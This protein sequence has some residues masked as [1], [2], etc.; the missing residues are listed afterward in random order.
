MRCLPR[1]KSEIDYLVFVFFKYSDIAFEGFTRSFE[2]FHFLSL[3]TLYL[4]PCG[5]FTIII[6]LYPYTKIVSYLDTAFNH[7]LIVITRSDHKIISFSSLCLIFFIFFQLIIFFASIKEIIYV[8]LT[9]FKL[10]NKIW[11][12]NTNKVLLLII[13][14]VTYIGCIMVFV[15]LLKRFLHC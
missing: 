4:H 7:I 8:Q 15:V 9:T 11:H 3:V 6:L 13:Y 10:K 2:F 5:W 14:I 1:K 12:A